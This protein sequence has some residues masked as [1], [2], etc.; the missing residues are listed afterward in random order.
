[1][2]KNINVKAGEQGLE[3][4]Y[5]GPKPDVLPLDD[6]PIFCC[7]QYQPRDLSVEIGAFTHLNPDQSKVVF[8]YPFS[9][10]TRIMPLKV[11]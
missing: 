1:M 2:S 7:S 3:P 9:D 11:R 4:R 10:R 8:A 6:S 5:S